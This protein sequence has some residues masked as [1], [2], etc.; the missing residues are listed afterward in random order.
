MI[1]K[2][3][4]TVLHRT[5]GDDVPG[6]APEHLLR[7]LAHGVDPVDAACVA[8][9][10][11][12]TWLGDDDPLALC[13]HHGIGRAEIDREV[14]REPAEDG[15]ENQTRLLRSAAPQRQNE[16]LSY[17]FLKAFLERLGPFGSVPTD[18]RGGK[19]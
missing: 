12:H 1:S 8:H 2:S 10:G 4:H 18:P 6:R 16:L 19:R 15:I 17:G 3:D 7:L 14:V 11:N 9:H 5:D 13:V